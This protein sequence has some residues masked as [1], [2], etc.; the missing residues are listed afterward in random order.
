MRA[1]DRAHSSR[2]R[3]DY[4]VESLNLI[5][6]LLEALLCWQQSPSAHSL[7]RVTANTVVKVI[8]PLLIIDR[9]PDNPTEQVWLATASFR[10]EIY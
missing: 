3:Q 9:R 1:S 6:L 5:M 4:K 7:Q 8:L 10:L 2:C